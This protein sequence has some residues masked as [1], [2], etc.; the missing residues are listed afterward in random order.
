MSA[1]P[2]PAS[3]QRV[4][5]AIALG[6]NLGDRE[7]HLTAALRALERTPGVVVLRRSRWVETEAVGGPSGQPR[8][9]NGAALLETTL[10]PRE[11]LDALLR[12][13]RARGRERAGGER[14]A[15][16]TLDLDL[17]LHGDARL[18]EPDLV[19]PHPR[20]EERLFVLE[21][22]AELVPE[23]RLPGCGETVAERVRTLHGGASRR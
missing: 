22:L 4:V 16:R 5:A 12:V 23:Q 13:E 1:P 19:V 6:S 20:M 7:A 11:L 17:L 2:S 9:L 3:G 8:F 10:G 14:D 21:P 15:P 18:D